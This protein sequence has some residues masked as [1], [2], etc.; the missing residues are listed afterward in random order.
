MLRTHFAGAHLCR[1][2]DPGGKVCAWVDVSDTLHP[3]SAAAMG[4]D[5]SRLLWVRCG[6]SPVT[7][8]L[9]Q[10][11]VRG[12]RMAE[13]PPKAKPGLPPGG[14]RT[15]PDGGQRPFCCSQRFAR[16]CSNRSSLRGSAPQT[17]PARQETESWSAARKASGCCHQNGPQEQVL[18]AAG[19]G[20]TGYGSTAPGRWLQLHRAGYGQPE[21]GVCLARAPGDMVSLPCCSRAIA[22]EC[23]AADP[24]CL[25][26]EQRRPGASSGAGQRACS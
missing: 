15:S 5:L 23:A 16:S 8:P 19:T 18:G 21:R 2:H 24:T 10:A 1:R 11:S 7:T 6:A 20:T 13:K 25:L 14:W 12:L 9:P 17:S 26:Q 22:I 3:E 4:V